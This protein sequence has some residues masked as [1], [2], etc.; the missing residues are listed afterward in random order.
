MK[1][2]ENINPTKALVI[3]VLLKDFPLGA[4]DIHQKIKGKDYYTIYD[5]IQILFKQGILIKQ[6]RKYC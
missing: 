4:R 1:P 5:A 3:E 2:Y 6:D